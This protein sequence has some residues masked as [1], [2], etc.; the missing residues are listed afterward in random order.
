MT[1]VVKGEDRDSSGNLSPSD[2][3][4]VIYHIAL[5][6]PTLLRC[7]LPTLQDALEIENVDGRL[8]F[9]ELFERIFTSNDTPVAKVFGPL[10]AAFLKRANDISVD[11]RCVIVRACGRALEF[12]PDFRQQVSLILRERTLDPDERVRQA[13]VDAVCTVAETRPDVVES[14]LLRSLT[15]RML[16]KKAS[17]RQ[18]ALERMAKLF[19]AHCARYWSDAKPV[20]V[21]SKKFS[22]IPQQIIAVL[23]ASLADRGAFAAKVFDTKLMSSKASVKE[24]TQLLLAMFATCDEAHRQS[25]L[26]H[27]IHLV[28]SGKSKVRDILSLREKI[29]RNDAEARPGVLKRQKEDRMQKLI[30]EQL[31][32]HTSLDSFEEL[33]TCENQKVFKYLGV[34]ANP[35][36]KYMEILGAKKELVAAIKACGKSAKIS[37]IGEQVGECIS[38]TVLGSDNI[39]HLL[40]LVKKHFGDGGNPKLANDGLTIL[41]EIAA[42]SPG[43]VAPHIELFAACLQN[44]HLSQD[45]NTSLLEVIPF[46]PINL[47]SLAYINSLFQIISKCATIEG[48]DESLRYALFCQP[49]LIKS[50]TFPIFSEYTSLFREY[51]L[52][53]SVDEAKFAAPVLVAIG[54]QDRELLEDVVLVNTAGRY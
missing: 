29:R 50:H 24:R 12:S 1:E 42:H 31:P 25:F 40:N 30:Q 45:S 2:Q 53:G 19:N 52:E 32:I 27:F 6:E 17:V 13:A 47:H 18:T 9:V 5:I 36:S 15:G 39:P 35:A 21:H 37:Q 28:S 38:G 51:A 33:L 23:N 10:F 26:K 54:K 44:Q 43:T 46:F 3:M 14:E 16:D 4:D 49:C 41:L 11:I 48:V 20:P 34:L 8:R 22:R 7:V